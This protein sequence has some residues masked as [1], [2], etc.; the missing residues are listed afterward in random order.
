MGQKTI[1]SF[2]ASVDLSKINEAL[3]QDGVVI[4]RNIIAHDTID[5][6]L[7][8]LNPYLERKPTCI[9]NFSGF[10]TKRLHS[11]FAKTTCL[12]DFIGHDQ[13]LEVMDL[14]LGPFCDNY[15]LNSNSIT[16]IGPGETPQ[17]LHRDDLLYPLAHPSKRNACATAFWALSDFTGE[18]G[19][20]RLVP[21]SHH[22][23][24]ERKPQEHETVQAI[25]PK[26]S[27][28]VFVGGVYHGGSPNSTAAQWRIG[29][30]SGYCLGWLRQEQNFYLSVPPDMAK[31]MPEKI[32]RLLG[33]NIHR[34][35][36]GW[37]Q[38][39]QDP[40]DV[41]NGYEELSKGGGSNMF[42]AGEENLV[43]RST[44]DLGASTTQTATSA[45]QRA[46]SRSNGT[47]HLPVIETVPVSGDHVEVEAL[48][49]RDGCVIIRDLIAPTS[50]DQ[51]LLDLEPY[52]QRK[53]KGET[54]FIGM[55]TKR[56]HSLFTKSSQVGD[57]V[58]NNKLLSVVESALRPFCDVFQLSSNSI[59]AIGPS[60]TP[61]PIH[62]GDSLYPLP[63]DKPRNLGITVFFALTDFTAENGATHLIPGSH[64]W[65]DERQPLE[66]ETVQA[67]MPKGS[68]CFFVNG[69][70]HGGGANRTDTWRIGMFASYILGWLRQ[71]QNFYLSVPPEQAKQLP[72]KV[73]RLLGYSLH[74]PFLGWVQDFQ[75]PWDVIQG[76]Q[77][78]SSGSPDLFA[79]D[80]D[81]PVQAATI[82][83][84]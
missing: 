24:D 66:S 45:E 7:D 40:W 65:D 57:F 34:P 78:L 21:G 16:A 82:R 31:E 67:V 48:L 28:C 71:E 60:E 27:V 51:L 62:R 18:N 55:E 41:I 77:E 4:L 69:I 54:D 63:H 72:E 8:E 20:T 11:L 47:N 29:M 30:F 52:L 26:G 56:L 22:W 36:L 42:A 58:T 12:A 5:T 3:E 38:D 50:I 23:D 1:Q 43:Q 84:I 74:R 61:Q 83:A 79:D 64:T 25:M 46:P 35:Y 32:G 2:E 13:V 59:T 73:A 44:I 68:A 76:Y 33:Y 70:Y 10:D 53:P 80:T 37:V 17:P 14:A 39:L 6:L 75:D 15:Q 9:G 19:A 81:D 49:E